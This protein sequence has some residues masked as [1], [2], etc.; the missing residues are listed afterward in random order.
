MNENLMLQ[1][2]LC[3]CTLCGWCD[4]LWLDGMAPHRDQPA[5]TQVRTGRHGDSETRSRIRH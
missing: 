5:G 3:D 1:E 4:V 2:W